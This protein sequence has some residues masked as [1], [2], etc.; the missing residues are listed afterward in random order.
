MPSATDFPRRLHL[1]DG[2]DARA[3]RRAVRR[4][5]ARELKRISQE[6]G[7]P[8]FEALREAYEAAML[9]VEQY[10]RAPPAPGAGPAPGAEAGAAGLDPRQAAGAVL[11][12]L[13]SAG[14][15]I[16]AWATP[17]DAGLWQ[18]ELRRSL[19][20]ARLL[21][22]HAR[23]LFEGQL[24]DLLAAG[25]RPG[26]EGLFDAAAMVF[27]WQHD[28][29][30]LAVLGD[31]G[32][33]L[34]RAI[35]E[36]YLFDF[37]AEAV[38][39]A[40]RGVLARLREPAPPSHAELVRYLPGA[41]TLEARF[42][43]WLQ[44][45]S[46]IP[47]VPQWRLLERQVPSWK[48]WFYRRLYRLAGMESLPEERARP[49]FPALYV[50]VAVAILASALD[51]VVPPRAV[52]TAAFPRFGPAQAPRYTS[53]PF[54]PLSGELLGRIKDRIRYAPPAN[55][56]GTG[57]VEYEVDLK[58]DGT[59]FRLRK[60]QASRYL[61]FD[62]AVAA[63]IRAAQPFPADAGRRLSGRFWW[64]RHPDAVRRVPVR[65]SGP[66]PDSGERVAAPA[67]PPGEAPE[68]VGVVLVPDAA[69]AM[70]AAGTAAVVP[71][72]K[73]PVDAAPPEGF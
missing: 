58:R 73:A 52:P 50:V 26:H 32:A 72:P 10:R 15:A 37:Q 68:A 2:A 23:T 16:A 18:A 9:W 31:A 67:A 39:G 57:V 28:R 51:A 35:D 70:P 42:P 1:E 19:A 47:A 41:D 45:V 44:L 65:R 17:D 12:Q 38:R 22:I 64:G 59:L 29:R 53:P 55:A 49:L 60:T 33:L 25:W 46:P 62:H 20:D 34:N 30:R 66:P 13:L 21:N 24:A 61:A 11:E 63:A 56:R 43:H 14:G 6:R 3:V 7:A 5:Y 36:K 40:L 48:R 71:M 69:L 8:G 4:A 27:G 54:V